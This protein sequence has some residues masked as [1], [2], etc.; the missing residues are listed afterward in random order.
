MS[1]DLVGMSRI[2]YIG[3]CTRSGSTLIDRMLG[4]LP[5]FVST[6]ELALIATNSIGSNRLCGCGRRFNE[7]PFWQAVG[8][9]AFGGWGSPEVEELTALYPQV[10]RQRHIPLIIFPLL[11]TRF[12]TKLRRYRMLIGKLYAGVLSVSGAEIV[13]DSS[14]MPAY[15]LVLRGVPDVD[16]RILHLVRDSRA[17]AYSVS[18]KDNMKDSLDRAVPK[19]QFSAPFITLV[20]TVYHLAFD[21]IRISGTPGLMA[22]YEDVV[23]SPQAWLR[24]IAAFAGNP[25]SGQDLDFIDMPNLR[26]REDHTAVGNDSRLA[27]G[28]IKLRED[29]VWR[30]KFPRSRRRLVTFMSWPLLKRWH[31]V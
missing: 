8:A 11:S 2:L 10:T 5:G 21:C 28:T 20:W 6:G 26:L 19:D 9:K 27:Q 4:Q 3:G 31:Y 17:T 7:C 23:R 29:D 15:A 13:V 22:R 30:T 12:A 25:P 24:R 18:K 16:L 1:L 14:K